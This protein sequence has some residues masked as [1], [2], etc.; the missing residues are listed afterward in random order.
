MSPIDASTP[1]ASYEPP[2]PVQE[3]A[4]R[5]FP[6]ERLILSVLFAVIAWTAF[7]AL[8]LL[9]AIMWILIAVSR[10]PHPEFRRF[11]SA[12]AKYVGQCL[13]YVLTLSDD[14]P[15]PLGPLPKGDA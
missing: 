10:E 7:W 15:F 4:P 3:A 8:L 13:S 6:W 2:T 14:K 1:D 9:A 5:S 12:G 11:V